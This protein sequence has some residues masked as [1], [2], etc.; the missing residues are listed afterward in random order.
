MLWLVHLLTKG[1]DYQ[2]VRP[3]L[4]ATKLRAMELQAGQPVR[5]GKQ[6]RRRLRVHGS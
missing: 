4:V 6:A 3:A 2:W 1:A 5:E